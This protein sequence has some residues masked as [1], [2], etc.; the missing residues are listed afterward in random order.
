[1]LSVVAE[2][3]RWKITNVF[4]EEGDLRAMLC[5]FATADQRPDSRP[6]KCV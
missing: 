5:Q 2:A 4:Y 3:G 6:A 1:V